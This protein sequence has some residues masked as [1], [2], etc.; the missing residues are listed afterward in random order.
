MRFPRIRLVDQT[1]HKFR[2]FESV[3]EKKEKKRLT[4]IVG[5][6]LIKAPTKKIGCHFV[7]WPKQCCQ[8]SMELNWALKSASPVA[9]HSENSINWLFQSD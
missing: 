9:K 1:E 5:L 6:L 4:V 8:F 7:V 2:R 3:L